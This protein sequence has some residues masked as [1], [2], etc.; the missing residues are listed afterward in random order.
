MTRY[1]VRGSKDLWESYNKSLADVTKA[2]QRGKEAHDKLINMENQISVGQ[3]AFDEADREVLSLKK[4]LA[5]A[6]AKRT[7]IENENLEKRVEKGIISEDKEKIMLQFKEAKANKNKQR[8]AYLKSIPSARRESISEGNMLGPPGTELDI[9]ALGDV[10]GWAPGLA[11]F[12]VKHQIAKITINNVSFETDASKIFPDVNDLAVKGR[13]MEGQWMDGN[14]FTPLH[15]KDRVENYRGAFGDLEIEPG[16]G[17]K[18]GFFL[19]VGDLNDRGDYSELNFDIIRQLCLTSGGRAFALLG[20]HEEMLLSGNYKN[21]INNEE[22]SGFFESKNN[23]GSVR[24]RHEYIGIKQDKIEPF[25]QSIFFSYCAH[26]AHLLLTQEYVIRTILDNESKARYAKLTQDAL[27]LSNISDEKLKDI[28]SERSWAT[29]EF[30]QKWL[31]KVWKAEKEMHIPGAITVFSIGELLGLHASINAAKKFIESKRS[32]S[33]IKPYSTFNGAKIRLQLYKRLPGSKSPDA[34]LLWERDNKAWISNKASQKMVETVLAIKQR[35]PHI[36]HLVQGH[37]PLSGKDMKV[38]THSVTTPFGDVKITNLDIGMTPVYLPS[39]MTDKY[40]HERVPDGLKISTFGRDPVR[41]DSDYRCSG[42]LRIRPT[43][44][45]RTPSSIV[46]FEA[47]SNKPVAEISQNNKGLVTMKSVNTNIKLQVK[48]GNSFA[49]GELVSFDST[50]PASAG[51]Y[52]IEKG[53]LSNKV[54]PIGGL[55]FKRASEIRPEE[56]PVLL[57]AKRKEMEAREEEIKR[58][59]EMA[60]KAAAEKKAKEEALKAEQARKA[61]EEK[62][63]KEEALKAEQARKAAEE[64]KAKENKETPETALYENPKNEDAKS[65]RITSEKDCDNLPNHDDVL[66][67]TNPSQVHNENIAMEKTTSPFWTPNTTIFVDKLS[68]KQVKPILKILESLDDG[69]R[70]FV[71]CGEMYSKFENEYPRRT[72]FIINS[73]KFRTKIS[74]TPTIRMHLSEQEALPLENYHHFDISKIEKARLKLKIQITR[75]LVE[76]IDQLESI[77]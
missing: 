68:K 31:Q 32:E 15:T 67:N 49:S 24:L 11:N 62:K 55:I 1:Q 54:T 12:L 53:W 35:L 44:E 10:H 47:T 41:L 13:P 38:K 76:K 34:D 29:L 48:Q 77:E 45:A 73:E 20:N 36:T 74:S 42:G 26:F 2:S 57:E 63:A 71:I 51:L 16:I 60:R 3:K 8:D 69:N 64:K 65:T 28:A 52:R 17:L 39:K 70:K 25:R 56:D 75:E 27:N 61:A 14:P 46:I 19:Q 66:V 30:C 37:E 43:Y 5:A 58:K 7:S 50:K 23:P 6:E 18:N 72:E 33:F 22:Q 59:A 40:S 9:H 21:W 4:Q